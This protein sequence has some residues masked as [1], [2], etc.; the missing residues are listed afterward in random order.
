MYKRQG[1]DCSIVNWL[2]E[3]FKSWKDADVF[4]FSTPIHGFREPTLFKE[5]LNSLPKSSD[6]KVPVFVMNSCGGGFGNYYGRVS[7]ILLSKNA[8]V[9]AIHTY[10]A[11]SNCLMWDKSFEKSQKK[12]DPKRDQKVLEFAKNLPAKCE[13]GEPVTLKGKTGIGGAMTKDWGL[14]MMVKG[15]IEV[16]ESKCKKCGLCAI[17]CFAK[18]ITLDPF[19][20][21]S[22]EKKCLVCLSCVNLCP[23]DALDAKNTIGKARYKGPGKLT[24]QPI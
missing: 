13:K 20:V 3:D 10:Y 4:G 7:K 12:V 5:K 24:I 16:D 6:K 1:H 21:F 8:N 17:N 11:P 23:Q 2:Q 18:R 15:E 19:P 22:K 14:R 9:V